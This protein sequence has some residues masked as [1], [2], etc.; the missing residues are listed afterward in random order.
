VVNAA[1]S[2]ERQVGG[3][4]TAW[5]RT[6]GPY[7]LALITAGLAV[8]VT[9]LSWPFFAATPFIPLFGAVL[10]TT[11][12]GS[13]PAGLVA[14]G[15]SIG[16]AWIAF[17]GTPLP[18]APRAFGVYILVSFISNRVLVN[19]NRVEASLRAREAELQAVWR[20]AAL[21]VALVDRNGCI[22]R[23]NPAFERLFGTANAV[24]TGTLFTAC[25]H[26]DEL[27]AERKRFARLMASD[28][29]A[30]QSEH[31]F[32][33]HDGTMFWGRVTV[34]AIRDQAGQTIG[35]MAILEDVSARR[36]AELDLRVSEERLRRA[37]K[38]EAIGR[39][40]AG[41]AHNFNNLLTVT[42]GYAE[43][44]LARHADPDRDHRDLEE[45]RKAA[46]R[47]ATLARQLLTFGRRHDARVRHIDLNRVVCDLRPML[48]R[49]I[50][51]DIRLTLYPASRSAMVL[52]DPH[53]VEQMLLNLVINARDAL[54]MGGEITIDLDVGQYSMESAD[55]SDV[56][57]QEAVR[58]RVC[59]TGLGMTPDVRARLFEPFFTTK[60]VGQ[61]T[62][63]GLAFIDGLVRHHRGAIDVDSTP[64]HG[65][66]FSIYLPIASAPPATESTAPPEVRQAVVRS[67]ATILLVEDES[68][69]RT[70][71]GRMLEHVGYRVL[72]AA[73]PAEACALFD[74]HAQEVTV[75]V[76][77][78]VMPDMH[79]PA[80]AQRLVAQRPDLRVLFMSG[81]S[82]AIPESTGTRRTAFLQKPFVAAHLVTTV[83]AL[84]N[85]AG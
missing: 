10:I 53:D 6:V 25:S 21:G 69:V 3:N 37:Q 67:H 36:Q 19:R 4:L 15:L 28:E 47:G 75:L 35:A 77:D 14:L 42:R 20:H 30:Y 48:L 55:N 51:E 46:D 16:G 31:R 1:G 40:V 62:G 72:S 61:G 83:E 23:L 68:P 76:T 24:Y 22:T 84:L 49:V 45:I 41:V 33:R 9:R 27:D 63:L 57:L 70:L 52:L 59:D 29:A 7:A 32:Q 50:R 79:G 85:A 38:L 8:A 60:D 12:V 44:L 58:L 82:D 73:T 13:G 17:P 54:P 43:L 80:L 18:V 11:H 71:T 26:D 56:T 78:V 66:T 2:S 64:G 65:T 74:A 81:Y 34:S 5:R 39:L